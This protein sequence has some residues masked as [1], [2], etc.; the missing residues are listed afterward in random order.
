MARQVEIMLTDPRLPRIAAAIKAAHDFDL[1]A[2]LR[3]ALKGPDGADSGKPRSPATVLL[4]SYTPLCPGEASAVAVLDPREI[5]RLVREQESFHYG[6]ALA[7]VWVDHE[8]KPTPVLVLEQAQE[9]AA[10]LLAWAEGSPSEWLKLHIDGAGQCYALALVPDLEQ[11]VERRRLAYLEKHGEVPAAD[12]HFSVW[13]RPIRFI[14][15]TGGVYEQVWGRLGGASYLGLLDAGRFDAAN[16]GAVDAGA[17]L[18][19]GPFAWGM[20]RS[21]TSR[22]FSAR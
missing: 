7:C 5:N 15:Q 2:E 20:T 11:V 16:P 17:V 6:Q 19:V 4:R 22:A 12:T 14:A 3:Q 21:G 1:V 10:H 18:F 13:L 8:G 9:I